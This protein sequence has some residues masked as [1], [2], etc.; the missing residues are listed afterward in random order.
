M[1]SKLLYA[2]HP[3]KETQINNRNF[4]RIRLNFIIRFRWYSFHSGA[5][6][7]FKITSLFVYTQSDH[8]QQQT[9]FLHFLFD[10]CLFWNFKK[11]TTVDEFDCI[12]YMRALNIHAFIMCSN[13]STDLILSSWKSHRQQ[14]FSIYWFGLNI[15]VICSISFHHINIKTP[16]NVTFFM[17]APKI[18][19]L[20]VSDSIRECF[21]FLSRICK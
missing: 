17:E 6:Y 14:L 1:E 7:L 21:F 19:R 20:L 16:N 3:H 11:T 15:I 2:H 13:T 12:T 8:P 10:R 9:H 5:L 4:F 18:N